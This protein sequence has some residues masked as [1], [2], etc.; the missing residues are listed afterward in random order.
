MTQVE[1]GSFIIIIIFLFYLSNKLSSELFK[2][3]KPVIY[4]GHLI[5]TYRWSLKTV[6]SM[7]NVPPQVQCK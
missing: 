4:F 1:N 6:K 3:Q 7:S 2:V 5:I